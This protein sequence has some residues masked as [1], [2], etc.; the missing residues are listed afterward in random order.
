MKVKEVNN[1]QFLQ[2]SRAR[3]WLLCLLLA[4]CGGGAD[5]VEDESSTPPPVIS[6][7]VTPRPPACI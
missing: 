6:C 5:L 4:G 7:T 1:L 3:P 2:L